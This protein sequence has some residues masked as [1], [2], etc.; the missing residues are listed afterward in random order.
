MNFI[1]TI[2]LGAND[3]V[4]NHEERRANIYIIGFLV[5]TIKRRKDCKIFDEID[6]L[7]KKTRLVINSQQN[8]LVSNYKFVTFIFEF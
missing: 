4:I 2:V 1:L 8:L 7:R 5:G 6:H 3:G